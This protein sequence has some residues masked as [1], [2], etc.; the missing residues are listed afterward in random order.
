MK[1]CESIGVKDVVDI[2]FFENRTNGQSKGIA[3]VTVETDE[4][5]RKL[6]SSLPSIELNGQKPHV[7]PANRHSLNQLDPTIG[8]SSSQTR[9]PFQSRSSVYSPPSFSSPSTSSNRFRH[10][11]PIPNPSPLSIAALAAALRPQTQQANELLTNALSVIR[12][13]LNKPSLN[14]VPQHSNRDDASYER[15]MALAK[16]AKKRADGHV[17]R[18]EYQNAID[19][20]NQA[21]SLI[22]KSPHKDER[23]SAIVSDLRKTLNDISDKRLHNSS[24]ASRQRDHRRFICF[25]YVIFVLWSIIDLDLHQQDIHGTHLPVEDRGVTIITVSAVDPGRHQMNTVDALLQVKIE[26]PKNDQDVRSDRTMNRPA[27]ELMIKIMNR[28]LGDDRKVSKTRM[29]ETE[30]IVVIE[31]LDYATTAH[32][33]ILKYINDLC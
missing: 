11:P 33:H 20:I 31:G 1:A 25:A 14:S 6:L 17:E 4:S 30:T 13:A 32:T 8:A 27:V 10:T 28:P 23:M 24:R 26:V 29:E 2:K 15:N 5:Y 7:T 9:P 3:S 16:S 22:A 21:I 18:R 12:P 19:T